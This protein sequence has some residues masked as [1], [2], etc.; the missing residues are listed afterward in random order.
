MAWWKKDANPDPGWYY[1]TRTG[2]V[3]R[4]HQA[5]GIDLLGPYPDEATARRALE[6]ARERNDKADEQE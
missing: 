3:E 1:N 6:I 4:G 2:E 5:R